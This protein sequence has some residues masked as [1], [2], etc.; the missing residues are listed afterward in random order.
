MYC[1][2]C[3]R[4]TY[5]FTFSTAFFEEVREQII[6]RQH[7]CISC[8]LRHFLFFLVIWRWK[9]IGSLLTRQ[10]GIKFLCGKAVRAWLITCSLTMLVLEICALTTKLVIYLF[11]RRLD[12]FMVGNDGSNFMFLHSNIYYRM[13]WT[14]LSFLCCQF[15]M[16]HAERW[17]WTPKTGL[18][19]VKFLA[20]VLKCW[21]HQMNWNQILWVEIFCTFFICLLA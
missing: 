3:L 10:L 12:M 5:W 1:S 16:I 7:S 11:V 6:R 4:Q 20:V 8:I 15:V 21:C 19:S 2:L 9:M 13:Q 17:L 14:N 18:W